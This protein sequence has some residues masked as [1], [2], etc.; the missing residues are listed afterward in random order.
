MGA[1]GCQS[2]KEINRFS[3]VPSGSSASHQ[4]SGRQANSSEFLLCDRDPGAP[5][6]VLGF[7]K[8]LTELTIANV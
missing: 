2:S 4:T 6:V 7:V 8:A 1:L 5:Q 3:R